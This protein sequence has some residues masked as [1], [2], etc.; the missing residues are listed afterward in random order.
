MNVLD[1]YLL[2]SLH[3]FGRETLYARAERV[4]KD[5]DDL[6]LART[7]TSIP[8]VGFDG[9][10]L[11][12]HVQPGFARSDVKVD[13]VGAYTLGF[14]HDLPRPPASM[15]LGI[16]VQ[17]TM[18]TVPPSLRGVYGNSIECRGEVILRRRPPLHRH[19]LFFRIGANVRTCPMFGL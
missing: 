5:Q 16:G 15:H 10:R 14:V 13:L 17:I 9:D 2:E 12:L 18:D 1:A 3:R 8:G 7:L 6:G 11:D 4:Q 19:Y